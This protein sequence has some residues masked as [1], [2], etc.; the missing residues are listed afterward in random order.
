MEVQVEFKAKLPVK[1]TR[2]RKYVVAS[3]PILDVV[4][5]GETEAAAKRNLREA[6][7]LF[8]LSCFERGTLDAVLK[9][10]GFEATP[11]VY[12]LYN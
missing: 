12:Y 3:C 2:K 10:H 6:L 4:S 8:F 11:S 5:Q 1:I 7:S 9:H